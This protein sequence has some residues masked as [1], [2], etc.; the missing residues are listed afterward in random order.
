MPHYQNSVIYK[1]KRN[2]D[3]DDTDIYVGS[4]TNFKHRK[5]CHKNNCN[6]E[7]QQEYNF[8]VYQYIRNN[9]GWENWVM[10]PIEQYPCNNKDELK[11][12]ERY[13]IDLL[14]SKLNKQLPCRT[15]K[16]WRDDNKEIIKE[17]VKKKYEN[18]KQKI[19]EKQKEKVICNHCGTELNKSSL[20]KHQKTKKCIESQ[21]DDI[22]GQI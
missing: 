6:N 2:D 21:K 9:G 16:E 10:I 20:K 22:A 3:Y 19:L 11:I 17:K 8:P 15:E 12:R 1:L 5:N 7:K 18:N 14:K 13:Y 4:T